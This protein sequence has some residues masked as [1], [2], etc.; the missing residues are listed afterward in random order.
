M[1]PESKRAI[2]R[3]SIS[4]ETTIDRAVARLFGG[5]SVPTSGNIICYINVS[6]SSKAFSIL[7]FKSISIPASQW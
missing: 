6:I 1:I 2:S 3:P 7:F 4:A 5:A